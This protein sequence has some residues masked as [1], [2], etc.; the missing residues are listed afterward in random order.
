MII[1]I[2]KNIF[3]NVNENQRAQ[4][5]ACGFIIPKNFK[6]IDFAVSYATDAEEKQILMNNRP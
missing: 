2:K 3:L 5:K 6:S 1:Q 4:E